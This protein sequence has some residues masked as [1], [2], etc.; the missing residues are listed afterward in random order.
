MQHTASSDPED[1]TPLLVLTKF[2]TKKQ[3]AL[4]ELTA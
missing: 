2:Q 4:K 1:I 3:D